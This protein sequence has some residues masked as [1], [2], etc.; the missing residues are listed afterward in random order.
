LCRYLEWEAE[1]HDRLE[2]VK[3]SDVLILRTGADSHELSFGES[4]EVVLERKGMRFKFRGTIDRVDTGLDSRVD[5]PAR[6][7]AA[8]DYKSSI[9]GV[10]GGGKGAAW[11][12]GVVLQVPLYAYALTQIRPDVEVSRVEYRPLR[13]TKTGASPGKARAHCLQLYQVDKK[14]GALK[15]NEEDT[16]KMDRALDSVCEHVLNARA[17]KFQNSPAPSCGCPAYCHA[18]DICRVSSR[19]PKARHR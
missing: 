3:K 19:E 13:E 7:V 6:F 8:I 15:R 1:F 4:G 2:D 14:S 10:P 5:N 18:Y 11:E 17:G 9:G 16:G 12:E